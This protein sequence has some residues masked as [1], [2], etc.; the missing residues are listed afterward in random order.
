MEE[1]DIIEQPELETET[2]NENLLEKQSENQEGSMLGKFKDAKNLLEAYNNL[3]SEFTR[4]SQKL[5]EFQ[6]KSEE[7]AFFDKFKNVDEFIN[8]TNGSDTYKEEILEI[9]KDEKINNLP[10]KYL[11]AYE[12]AKNTDSNLAKNLDNPKFVED[13]ILK[14]E[15]VKQKVI[16]DYLS[17]LNKIPTPPNIVSGNSNSIYFSPEQSRPTTIKQAGE[18]FSKMLK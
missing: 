8:A 18:I 10:N 16:L 7:N 11:I 3:Q 15:S 5:A 13:K 2:G 4:K 12:I 9:L 6:K 14:N 17:N 1:K